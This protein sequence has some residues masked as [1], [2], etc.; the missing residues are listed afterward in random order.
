MLYGMLTWQLVI[1]LVNL[2]DK[3][4]LGLDIEGIITGENVEEVGTCL[5]KYF[6]LRYT[7]NITKFISKYIFKNKKYLSE[8]Y[9]DKPKKDVS[10]LAFKKQIK[11]KDNLT[12]LTNLPSIINDIITSSISNE[13]FL[14]YSTSTDSYEAYI[15]SGLISNNKLIGDFYTSY[16][17][18]CVTDHEHIID[19]LMTE[20]R[21]KIINKMSD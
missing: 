13:E 19:E 21:Q 14:K 7:K 3:F 16:I 18:V 8:K 4:N 20:I 12:I 1:F 10:T 17:S 9:V 2:N 11:N 5:Y 6:I 15:I